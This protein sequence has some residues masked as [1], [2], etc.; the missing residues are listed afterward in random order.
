M[1]IREGDVQVQRAAMSSLLQKAEASEAAFYDPITQAFNLGT[2]IAGSV[3]T[4]MNL[5]PKA[6][7]FK[8][9]LFPSK[10]PIQPD[11][12][13]GQA[14]KMNYAQD[15]INSMAKLSL[16]DSYAEGVNYT[17]DAQGKFM[18]KLATDF[19]LTSRPTDMGLNVTQPKFNYKTMTLNDI[20]NLAQTINVIP[21][22]DVLSVPGVETNIRNIGP[23]ETAVSE[24]TLQ[25]NPVGINYE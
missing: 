12:V 24:S 16:G 13:Y 15:S 14:V 2:E 18:P 3:G 7:A 23:F 21:K 6:I 5:T 1:A 8:E 25:V 19:Q 22:D 4:M 17:M 20:Q 9:G 11:S 10:S